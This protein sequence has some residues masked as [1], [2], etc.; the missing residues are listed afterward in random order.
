MPQ[1]LAVWHHFWA[2]LRNRLPAVG[3]Q[4]TRAC[5]FTWSGTWLCVTLARLRVT[6]AANRLK[7]DSPV[8]T[9]SSLSDAGRGILDSRQGLAICGE[10]TGSGVGPQLF[11]NDD[12]LRI[13]H[14]RFLLE[15]V[16]S[17]RNRVRLASDRLRP[18]EAD[19]PLLGGLAMPGPA[20]SARD[21]AAPLFTVAVLLYFLPLLA[22]PI[23]DVRY[24]TRGPHDSEGVSPGIYASCACAPLKSGRR[25]GTLAHQG[26]PRA[27]PALDAHSPSSLEFGPTLMQAAIHHPCR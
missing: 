8:R 23:P 14:R 6:M 2:A 3:L 26:F 21:A 22:V 24:V 7:A 15:P 27:L 5:R 20:S 10:V 13:I 12:K 19:A 18:A 11:N 16:P 25:R 9:S 17:V 4:R 1:H